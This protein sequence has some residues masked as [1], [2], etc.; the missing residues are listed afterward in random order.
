MSKERIIEK[1][2]DLNTK[3]IKKKNQGEGMWHAGKREELKFPP[4]KNTIKSDP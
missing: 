1:W 2:R 4:F 3:E